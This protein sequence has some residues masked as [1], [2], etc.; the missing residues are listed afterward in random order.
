VVGLLASPGAGLIFFFP[1]AILLPISFRYMYR[2]NRSLFILS[3]Y[4]S[5]VSWL[6]FGTISYAEPSGW[7]GAGSWGPRYL[8]PT[9]PFLTV[10]SGALF[11]NLK[12]SRFFLKPLITILFVAGFFVNLLGVLVWYMYGYSYGW[13]VTGFNSMDVMTWNPYY[14]P[15]V[16]HFKALISDFTSHLQPRHNWTSYG[17]APCSYN[18][19]LFCKFG[20]TPILLLLAISGVIAG[21]ILMV[22]NRFTPRE[23][24]HYVK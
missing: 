1:I 24:T 15:I 7:S 10:V 12:R 3:A 23:F 14:S 11:L 20:I 9:L 8:I 17:L 2:K 21:R 22:I 19:Y 5:V 16:L 18:L 6:Y 13:E 4:V